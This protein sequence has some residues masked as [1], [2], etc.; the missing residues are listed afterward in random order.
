MSTGFTPTQL[1]SSAMVQAPMSCMTALPAGKKEAREMGPSNDENDRLALNR[2]PGAA[3]GQ[4]K[5]A[6]KVIAEV[7]TNRSFRVRTSGGDAAADKPAALKQTRSS[8]AMNTRPMTRASKLDAKPTAQNFAIYTDQDNLVAE[9][10]TGPAQKWAW[11]HQD[12]SKP[13]AKRDPNPPLLPCELDKRSSSNWAR[14]N[15]GNAEKQ[16]W[17]SAAPKASE[18]DALITPQAPLRAEEQVDMN[19]QIGLDN[20]DWEMDRMSLGKSD[21]RESSSGLADSSRRESVE[22][23]RG[24]IVSHTTPVAAGIR[25]PQRPLRTLEAI[26]DTLSQNFAV[27]EAC[28]QLEPNSKGVSDIWV[29]RYMDYTSKYGLGFLLN[30]GCSG[31]Y[32]NDSTK[33]VLSADGLVFQYFERRHQSTATSTSEGDHLKTTYML[34]S[35]PPE[36]IKK[37]TLLCHFKDYLLAR[38]TSDAPPVIEGKG[39]LVPANPVALPPSAPGAVKWTLE[40]CGSD[41]ERWPDMPYLKKWVRTRHAVLLRLSNRS[42][43]VS[44]FDTRFV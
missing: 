32:F 24:S 11:Q 17:R 8:S 14:E 43:Q 31:V 26:H 34:S 27:K 7:N 5:T 19:E 16:S 22:E 4:V 40:G 39:N 44:F 33:I 6:S 15:N 21:K 29:V 25:C 12:S 10:G 20:L 18:N 37:V 38:R 2:V 9:A 42:V 3:T 36:L 23:P 30:N 35:H 41:L 28:H 1:P 13:V